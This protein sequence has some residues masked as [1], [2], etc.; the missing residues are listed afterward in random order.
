[1]SPSVCCPSWV[2]ARRPGTAAPEL[3]LSET[4]RLLSVLTQS[5][6]C[7]VRECL[8]GGCTYS[9][10]FVWETVG[11]FPVLSSSQPRVA[12]FNPFCRVGVTVIRFHT[13]HPAGQLRLHRRLPDAA[14]AM[15]PLLPPA[16]PEAMPT[17]LWCTC[18]L[19]ASS[20][21]G[22]YWAPRT[23]QRPRTRV[24]DPQGP[25]SRRQRPGVEKATAAGLGQ[26]RSGVRG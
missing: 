17:P 9:Q 3:L 1:M 16:A 25:R 7:Q 15:R 26:G 19:S 24:P 20:L 4:H 18:A 8:V 22:V 5:I 10:C 13:S 6:E 11:P 14:T 2:L 12:L 23:L 21:H